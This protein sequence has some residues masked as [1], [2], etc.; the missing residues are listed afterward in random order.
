M[1]SGMSRKPTKLSRELL[2]EFTTMTE[3]AGEILVDM[4][5]VLQA[6]KVRLLVR[7]EALLK[8]KGLA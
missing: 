2:D 4:S 7:V 8:D 6:S 1:V 5:D 3:R